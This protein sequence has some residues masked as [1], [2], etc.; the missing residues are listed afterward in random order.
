MVTDGL[1]ALTLVTDPVER[2]ALRRAPRRPGEPI[3]GAPEWRQ[4]VLTGLLQAGVALG[5]FVWALAERDLVEA[6]NLA[7][8][9]L[10]FGELLRAF[11]ARSRTRV[12]W[13]AGL[14]SNLRLFGVVLVSFAVQIGIHHIPQL[15]DLFGIGVLS[16]GDCLLS[17][18]LGALPLLMLEVGKLL[19]PTRRQAAQGPCAA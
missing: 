13:E 4:I 14:F 18:L 19:H 15:R 2:D 1:P 12:F 6:R 16:T 8:S 10:V 5:V 9:T 3:L 7:F 11:A 17:I